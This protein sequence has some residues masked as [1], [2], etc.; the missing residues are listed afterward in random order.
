MDILKCIQVGRSHPLQHTVV[1]GTTVAFIPLEKSWVSPPHFEQ[2]SC[3]QNSLHP[4]WTVTS[5]RIWDISRLFDPNF[6]GIAEGSCMVTDAYSKGPSSFALLLGRV[7]DLALG[8]AHSSVRWEQSLG[9]HP[10]SAWSALC[11]CCPITGP[12][13]RQAFHFLAEPSES[14]DTRLLLFGTLGCLPSRRKI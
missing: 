10:P 1:S 13:R 2:R 9:A 7:C 11:W 3:H 6:E 14:S 4:H 5:E 8:A 12:V